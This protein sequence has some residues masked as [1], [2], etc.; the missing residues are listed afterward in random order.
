[1]A[2]VDTTI[3]Q[4]QA[5]A[6]AAV[7]S[8]NATLGKL[9]D[10]AS[11]SYF[12][13]SNAQPIPD[14]G[15][16]FDISETEALLTQM[17]PDAITVSDINAQR[18]DSFVAGTVPD[19]PSIAVPDFNVPPPTLNIPQTPSTALPSV[20][21]APSID[22]PTLPTAPTLTLPTAPTLA[23]ISF[24]SPPT[25]NLPDLT[26]VLPDD[27]LVAPDTNFTFSEAGYNDAMLDALKAKLMLDLENG[28]YGIEPL[29]ESALWERA[30]AREITGAMAEQD[31]L[32]AFAASR[33]FP[34]PP[35]DLNVV[36]QVSEQNLNDKVSA[37]SR[38][39]MIKRGDLYAETRK[40]TFTEVRE[41]EGLLIGL[42]NSITERSFQAAKAVLDGAIALFQAQVSRY[43]ARIER[44]K[45]DA[46]VFEARVRA[47]L[48]QTEIYRTQMEGARIQ[49]DLQRTQ[50]EVYNAQ[51]RGV[52]T[53]VDIYKTQMEVV[54]VQT[55][56]EQLRIQAF[57]ALVDAYSQQV[58]AKLAEFQ[59][60]TATITGETAKVQAYTAQAQAYSATVEG[61][62]VQSDV[63]IAQLRGRIEVEGQRIEAYKTALSTYQSDISAQ[64]ETIRARVSVYGSNV[65]GAAAKA[66]ALAEAHR[67]EATDHD[68]QFR[69]NVENA[70]IALADAEL[71]LKAALGSADA[72]TRAGAASA[73][74][75]KAVAG[76]ALGSIG[77]LAAHQLVE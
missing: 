24:P 62:R 50:V 32:L 67:L 2:D 49:S 36:L 26:A 68:L 61:K 74:A 25:I 53:L 11:T 42:Y 48:A 17:F 43:N 60:Y 7:D 45:A 38:D 16:G 39:I 65:Q 13:Q 19:L 34:L 77:T 29:D 41:L 40:F 76:S 63:L 27:D 18:P 15:F 4:Q 23:S 1:M 20:P 46:V 28:G 72:R 64:A 12:V 73:D 44:Y 21:T 14:P 22:E 47:A 5:Y 3:A 66:N 6:N 52:Q 9:D 69:R 31:G 56:I 55:G 37:L 70:K 59:M 10:L 57:R 71:F 75:Y 51:L 35:G 30:R 54:Q 8:M 58:Q 33:G